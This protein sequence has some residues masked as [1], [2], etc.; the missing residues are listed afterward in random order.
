[1]KNSVLPELQRHGRLNKVEYAYV[2]TDQQKDLAGKLLK[3]NSI[4]Q[5]IMFEKVGSHWTRKQLTGAQS[6]DDTTSFL[7]RAK[8]S[9]PPKTAAQ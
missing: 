2:N 5:L 6:M 8:Q 1:M 4:P 7:S 3:G 9:E